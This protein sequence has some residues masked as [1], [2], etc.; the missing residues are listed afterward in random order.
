MAQ[1]LFPAL[2]PLT[3]G[4]Q[5]TA[6]SIP[7]DLNLDPTPLILEAY[8][9]LRYNSVKQPDPMKLAEN[10]IAGMVTG[11]RD[12]W[13]AYY[14]PEEMVAFSAGVK[15]AFGG[16]GI[17]LSE[18]VDG[19]L[20]IADVMEGYP[21]DKAGLAAGD[22][23]TA[24]D[25]EDIKGLGLQAAARIRG[26]V[27]TKVVLTIKRPNVGGSLTFE[28]VRALISITS[29]TSRLLADQVG[30]IAVSSFDEDTDEEFDKALQAV[31]A[32]G[33]KGLIIDLRGNPGGI[34]EVCERMVDRFLPERYPYLRVRWTWRTD[35]VR[36][37]ARADY[38][39][40]AG[41]DYRSDGRFPYPVAILVNRFSASAS[42]IFTV[43]LQEWGAA[44]VFGSPTFGKG[45]VQSLYSLTGGGG[46]KM[47]TATWTSGLGRQIDGVGIVPDEVIDDPREPAPPEPGFIPLAGA[48][49]FRRGAFG[50]DVVNLQMRLKQLGYDVGVADGIFSTQTEAALKAFQAAVGLPQTGV[51]DSRTVTAFNSARLADHPAGR[52]PGSGLTGKSL[53]GGGQPGGGQPGGGQPGTGS[54]SLPPVPAVTGDK[55]IDRALQWLDTE[56]TRSATSG[57]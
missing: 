23:I 42:E 2:S 7:G 32:E 56:M 13:A 5:D 49:V 29:V 44:R 26:E 36:S 48:W 10:A 9:L 47:T 15:G 38:A 37:R 8:G 3:A 57:T 54:S 27:G 40:L 16:I 31:V 25:G 30:Y 12:Y 21:G 33:A 20:L 28:L 6:A 51:T 41:I 46:M 14:T 19:Y 39:P 50:T 22:L 11:L 4:A 1:G 35:I 43:A 55:V 52:K 24:I 53:P 34:L 18:D 17:R 45:C